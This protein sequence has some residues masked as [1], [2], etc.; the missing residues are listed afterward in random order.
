MASLVFENVC[1]RYA[2]YNSRAQS[3]RNH[4]LNIST[5]G[6]IAQET[7]NTVTVTAL[8][9]ASFKLSDGDR[10]GVIGHNGA[11]KT[12]MLRTMAGI[13]QPISGRVKR[14]GMTNT[15]IELGAGMDPELS[16]FDNAI[17]M[18]ML[19]G[20]SKRHIEQAMPGI[21]SFTELGNYLAMPVRTY[22]TGM[23]MRL[24]FAVATAH[25][26]NILLIDEMFGAGD[27]EFQERAQDR[28]HE[29]IDAASIFVFASHSKD[30]VR[31]Y[32][33]RLL[34]LEHGRVTEIPIEAL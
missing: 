5:G 11:G 4:L 32:C 31:K 6:R 26:P 22:S 10:V 29:M 13:F 12:T 14:H 1:V 20:S 33:N 8:D 9:D 2:I 28:L 19:A 3:L 27:A 15:I 24:M 17:R 25:R 23:V 21:V 18:A 34:K 16:G 7:R 30:L